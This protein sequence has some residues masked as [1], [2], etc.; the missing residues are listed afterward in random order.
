MSVKARSQEPKVLKGHGKKLPAANVEQLAAL[1]IIN[2]SSVKRVLLH[3]DTATGKTRVFM[4][5]ANAVIDS[6]RS[7]LI[8][9][10]EIG[11]TPQLLDDLSKHMKAPVVLTHSELTPAER[12]RVWQYA[13]AN[14]K[15]TVYVGP[16]SALFL[17]FGN[18]GLIV[19]DEAHDASYKQGQSPRYQSL[20]VA[21][22][23]AELHSAQL[24]QSTATPNA[25]DYAKAQAHG[26]QI[27]RMMTKAVGNKSSQV[28]LVDITNRDNFQHNSYISDQLIESMAVA[29]NKRQQ[30]MLFLNRRGSAR[31]VQCD[32]CGWQALCPKCGLPLTYHHDYHIIRCHSCNFHQAAANSCPLCGSPD[33]IYKSIGTKS[34]VDQTARLFPKSRI[35]RFDADSSAAE[36]YYRHIDELKQ[37][38]FDI[39]IG[40]QLISKGINLPYLSVVGVINADSSL[41]LPDYR[42]EELTFQQLYQVTGRTGRGYLPSQAIIQTRLP[43]NPVMRAVKNRSWEEYYSY[44]QAK[45]Q[46]F[47]YPP[48]CF[49]AIF[50]IIK[51]NPSQ[52]EKM[53]QKAFD[54][55]SDIRGLT[56]LGP[57]PSFYEKPGGN[58]SWQIIAKAAKRSA[59][60]DVARNLSSDWTIDIDPAG[61]L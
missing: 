31:S 47:G 13:L 27:I 14:P 35:I 59:L 32:N 41:N 56:L 22:K 61:L 52:A 57:S 21:G 50:K 15:P 8:L 2:Q 60:V 55:L 43:D 38:Q 3:G 39:I 18:L 20:Y 58:Y 16:R 37:G 51:K 4:D 12:R 6:G 54:Q 23:L 17:P 10:P 28:S 30:V 36:Q 53:S 42:A 34:L 9:T 45:R 40:T 26:Y 48:F 19:I 1:K 5:K 11:L 29:L 33:L 24:L 46:Q 44:E 7:V 49:L 25:D